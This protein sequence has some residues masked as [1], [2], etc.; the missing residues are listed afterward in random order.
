MLV[1][2]SRWVLSIVF[3]VKK[4]LNYAYYFFHVVVIPCL[5]PHN[6]SY[7]FPP[8]WV[9]P[10][11]YDLRDYYMQEPYAKEREYLSETD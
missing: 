6:W 11:I 8:T 10:Y 7:C 2:A 4:A 5:Q 1:T 9:L 3:E